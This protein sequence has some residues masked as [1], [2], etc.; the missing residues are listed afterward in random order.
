V[1]AASA[2]VVFLVLRRVGIADA[3][4]GRLGRVMAVGDQLAN[5]RSLGHGVSTRS[6]AVS[7]LRSEQLRLL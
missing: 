6:G 1:I 2:A 3:Q 4:R 5:D 7:V